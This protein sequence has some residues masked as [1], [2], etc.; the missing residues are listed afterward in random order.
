V[1]PHAHTAHAWLICADTGGTFTDCLARDPHGDLRRAKV[2]S[3]SAL[4]G[5][6]T[7]RFS[8]NRIEIAQQWEAC[9]NLIAGFSVRRLDDGVTIGRVAGFDATASTVEIAEPAPA[10]LLREGDVIEFRG[11]EPAPILAARLVTRTPAH[12][13]LPPMELRVATTRGTNALLERR[14]A[15]IALFITGG[16]GDLLAIG[17]QSRPDIFALRIVKSQPLYQHVVEVRE[18]L[19]AAGRVL[20]PLDEP[21]L[22]SAAMHLRGDGVRVAAVALLHSHVNPAHEQ[23]VAAILRECGFERVSISSEIAP[24]IRILPRAQTA[25]VDAYLDPLITEYLRQI[26]EGSAARTECM[27][28][29]V[30]TSAGALNDASRY[31]ACASL[32]SGPAG[33]VLGAAAAGRASGFQRVIGFDMGGTSTDVCRFDGELDYRFE[34]SVGDAKLL[35]PALAI[36]TVAAGGGSICDFVDG[37]MTVG[38]RSAGAEPGPACYGLGGPLTLTD[39]NLL[40]GRL[41]E[42][43]FEIPI[44]RCAAERAL[45]ELMDQMER[46]GAALT[47]AAPTNSREDI[48]SGFIQIANQRMASA[49]EEVSLRQG[50]DARDYALLAF[51]GAGGQHACAVAENL[52]MSR[53]VMPADASLLSAAGLMTA[54]IERFAQRQMLRRLDDS[55]IDLSAI[56]AEV[57]RQAIDEVMNEGVARDHIAVRRRIANLRLLGQDATLQ[58]DVPTAAAGHA[59]IVDTLRQGFVARYRQ[60]YGHVPPLDRKLIEIESLRI[61]A[62]STTHDQLMT[63]GKTNVA[64][65]VAE[66]SGSA[67]AHF[68][69]RW[70]DAP[71]FNRATLK[72]GAAFE[73]PAIVLDRRSSYVIEEGWRASIDGAGAI[74]AAG[75]VGT[76]A[77]VAHRPEIVRL[78]LFAN[79]FMSAA[80]EMGQMLQRTAL[81][82]NVKE[83]LD[84]SCTVL[85][86]QGQ[87]IANAPHLP[88]HLGAMGVCVRAVL[89]AIDMRPG[90]VVITNHPAFGGSHLPDVTLITPVFADNEAL[91]GFVANRAHHAEIGG[92][93]PGSMPPDAHTLSEE[94]VVIAPMHLVR[95]GAPQWEHVERLL[96]ESAYPSRAVADNL[97]DLQAQVAA[98]HR[99]AMALQALAREHGADEVARQMQAVSDHA[100]RLATET[101]RGL[102]ARVMEAVEHLDDGSRLAVRIDAR[103]QPV[104]VDFA[105]SSDQHAGNLN[106]TPA[107]VRSAVIYVLR[108]LVGERL[109]LN[110]G[111]MREV[112]VRIP[113]GSMLD[114]IFD[115]HDP[116]RCPA[117]VGGNTETS[118]RLVDTLLK[119]FGLAACSQGTMNNTLFGNDRFGYYETVCG[120]SGAT[121]GGSGAHAVHVHMTN[122]RITDPEIIEHRYPVRIERFGIR[123][124]SGGA[125]AHRGGDGAAREITFLE[126]MSLSMLS[127]HRVVEPYGMDGG[128]PGACG[129]QRVIRANG[130]V[131][132]LKPIDGCEVN[133]GDRLVLETPGG[134]GW[135]KADP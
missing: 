22:H 45:C 67:R 74:V 73:G 37:R 34:H 82:T 9:D 51:G 127:Q 112:E 86:A 71:V 21:T 113:R 38:P 33:G 83:R 115:V 76:R 59:A 104:V 123:R 14:G 69:G 41:D 25:V 53:V 62:A 55:G 4:R 90:D 85:D 36:E 15:E 94:G 54:R 107:I 39:V 13:A 101:F 117:V 92:T 3:T 42:A 18:R 12:G 57:A 58:V 6:V 52:G 133:P 84:F 131:I 110:E 43:Q 81:S 132:I 118:Q 122:T 31:R 26:A 28:V 16:F 60:M 11:D 128:Q 10:G 100:A 68:G 17:D 23:H 2:L 134:G 35:A 105:G 64:E 95:Q 111:L 93:R 61:V 70:I 97:A 30:M 89:E 40:L 79:R 125:G 65:H 29:R 50:H 130:E 120:G 114:P 96:G 103:G 80:S 124:G 63:V 7:R 19:D 129:C 77:V 106:A 24:L 66:S 102:P 87:L 47:P 8:P 116:T 32:L 72:R 88:V 44:Q 1:A 48:L 91:I 20:T 119:A 98:N 56:V 135:R 27:Q 46:A 5:R 78:E 99:G 75:I 109:P 49:I 126:P 108:L 121:S